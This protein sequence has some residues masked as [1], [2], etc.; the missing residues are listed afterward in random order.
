M[1]T[2]TIEPDTAITSEYMDNLLTHCLFGDPAMPDRFTI[3]IRPRA[4]SE[5]ESKALQEFKEGLVTW[6][7]TY[8]HIRDEITCTRYLSR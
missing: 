1:I 8:F 3:Y 2:R 4:R 5:D 7:Y 6:N